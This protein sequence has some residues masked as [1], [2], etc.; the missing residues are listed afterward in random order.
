[1]DY[2]VDTDVLS[3]GSPLRDSSALADWLDDNSGR[4]YVSTVTVAEIEDG[5][6]K[7]RREGATRKAALLGQWLE[8]VLHLYASRFLTFDLAAARI[9]GPLSD[10]ARAKGAEPGFAD[11]AIAAIAIANGLTILTRNSKHFAPLDVSF[12][13]PFNSLP[14]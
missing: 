13:D 11:L 10:V 2:L 12:H 6:A 1:M 9:A 7:A 14:R 3:A 5:I 8:T 4:L